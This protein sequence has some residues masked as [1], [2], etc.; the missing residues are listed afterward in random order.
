MDTMLI[1][2]TI[3]ILPCRQDRTVSC[4]LSLEPIEDVRVMSKFKNLRLVNKA[5]TKYCNLTTVFGFACIC[6]SDFHKLD[7]NTKQQNLK[8]LLER[9]IVF[10]KMQQLQ[11]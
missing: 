11:N 3:Y 5:G 9:I 7:L 2:T 8:S 1:Q 10:S 4:M 6:E